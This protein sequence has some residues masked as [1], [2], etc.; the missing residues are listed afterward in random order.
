M[1]AFTMTNPSASVPALV[2]GL[3]LTRAAVAAAKDLDAKFVLEIKERQFQDAINSAMGMELSAVAQP[4]G[5]PEPTGPGAAFAPPALMAAPVPGQTFEVRARLANRGG[6]AA[7]METLSIEGDRGWQIDPAGVSGG[8]ALDRH[9]QVTARVRVTLADDVAISTRPY[10]SRNGLQESRYTLSDP[11]QFGRAASAPPLRA[12]ARYVI[13]GA[14]IE[15]RQTVLR[16]ESKLPYGD[17]LREV[18][19][20]PRVAVTMH[21]CEL[22]IVPFG[23]GST[24]FNGRSPMD[25]DVDRGLLAQRGGCHRRSG[26]AQDAGRLEGRAGV[27]AVRLLQIRRA[28][29]VSIHGDAV[30][31]R[32]QAVHD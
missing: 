29:V 2:D 25:L 3:K 4:A 10:F 19:S 30:V 8:P 31:D 17:V 28:I 5:V 13:D 27:A 6:V 15:I 7:A 18:R 1:A 22:S 21:A 26:G 11:S 23:A 14:S 32:R 20:V 16:R 24:K 9:Q 12:V